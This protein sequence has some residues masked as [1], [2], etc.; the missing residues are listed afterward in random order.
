M[1]IIYNIAVFKISLILS[2]LKLF[3]SKVKKFIDQRNNVFEI[4]EKNISKT[5]KYI[6][7][8]VGSLGE[9]EQGLP[10][11]KELKKILVLL[12]W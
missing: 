10:V 7:I 5:D 11:F 9:Y 6:W 8:H 4:L 1:N 12:V 3:N 2:F